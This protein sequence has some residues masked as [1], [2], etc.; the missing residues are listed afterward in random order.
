MDVQSTFAKVNI[1]FSR[2]YLMTGNAC[3]LIH[4]K[5]GQELNKFLEEYGPFKKVMYVGDG[6]VS[7]CRYK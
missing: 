7:L 2:H 1:G 3:M 4:L 5:I 6:A